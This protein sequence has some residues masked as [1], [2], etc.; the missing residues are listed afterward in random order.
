MAATCPI[1]NAPL[2]VELLA[3]L[4]NICTDEVDWSALCGRQ[5]GGKGVLLDKIIEI[6]EAGCD[7]S[8]EA[9]ASGTTLDDLVLEAVRLIGTMAADAKCAEAFTTPE[10]LNT[11]QDTLTAK[12]EDDEIV[13]NLLFVFY[14]LLSHQMT[15]NAVLSGMDISLFLLDLLRDNNA[16]V[17]HQAS[18]CLSIVVD[19]DPTI[20]KKIRQLK[21]EVHNIEWSQTLTEEH[22]EE[23]MIASSLHRKMRAAEGEFEDADE[24]GCSPG[25]PKWADAA[26]VV[27]RYW[28]NREHSD[29]EDCYS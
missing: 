25:G 16:C 4:A 11:L 13:A 29:E 23:L 21:F 22:H 26:A 9:I 14:C 7:E 6:L 2:L 10:C 17:R 5:R 28:T 19:E 1:E 3:I 8:T 18:L 24:E 15:R 12:Q 20:F 27:D